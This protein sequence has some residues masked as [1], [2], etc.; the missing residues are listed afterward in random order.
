MAG[1]QVLDAAGVMTA[2]VTGV[3]TSSPLSAREAAQ[4]LDVP[5]IDTFALRDP[6]T[7]LG[8]LPNDRR[9]GTAS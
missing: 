7:A 5:V 8:L 2:A 6:A 1:L 4:V 9:V 3:V